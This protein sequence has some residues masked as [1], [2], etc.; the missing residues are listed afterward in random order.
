MSGVVYRN[1]RFYRADDLAAAE[2]LAKDLA[3]P[4]GEM[5]RE[6][7][8]NT[9]A[10]SLDGP[11]ADEE[12][13]GES[14]PLAPRG[15]TFVSVP[16]ASL[17]ALVEEIRIGV[18]KKGGRVEWS[19]AGRERVADV[20]VPSGASA[21]RIFTSLSAGERAARECGKDAV[22]V[23][24]GALNPTAA[25]PKRRFQAT[26]APLRVFRTAPRNLPEA[27]RVAAFLER[28]RETL[29]ASY[30]AALDVPRCP[31]CPRGMVPR[32][33]SRGS[34]WGCSGYP[35]CRGTRQIG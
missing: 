34:F 18:E 13:P 26:E 33:G 22:R 17:E 4:H 8:E 28:L 32:T 24:V 29:R 30:R 1:G 9:I 31:L 20:I 2:E 19:K 23:V 7:Y 12:D 14:E 10:A 5:A 25:Q 16:A 15:G 35:D 3:E 27:E 11:L 21:I 6:L